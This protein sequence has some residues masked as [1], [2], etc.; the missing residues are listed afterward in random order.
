M[1]QETFTDME[2]SSRKKKM[3]REEFPEIM[4]KS[5]RRRSG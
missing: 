3:K 2:Y 5:S 1:K 4:G